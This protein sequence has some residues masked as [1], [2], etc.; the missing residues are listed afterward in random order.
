M[1]FIASARLCT[2]F[3]YAGGY[4]RYRSCVTQATNIWVKYKGYQAIPVK[5]PGDSLTFD[6]I[7]TAKKEL[8]P[9]MDNF[10]VCQLTLHTSPGALELRL[11]LS[12]TIA[13]QDAKNTEEEPFVI[14]SPE[15]FIMIQ[16][17]SYQ[18]PMYYIVESDADLSRILGPHFNALVKPEE[19]YK[20]ITRFEQLEDRTTYEFFSN[21]DSVYL[22]GF[23]TANLALYCLAAIA[24]SLW[25]R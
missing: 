21:F 25:L 18:M 5:I 20:R 15:K 12:L 2:H 3:R 16:V 6:I 11:G 23:T 7:K 14:K 17:N 13:L 1:G 9:A 8:S 19:R 22:G 10:S 24:A 4:H